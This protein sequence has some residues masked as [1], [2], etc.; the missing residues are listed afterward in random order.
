[1]QPTFLHGTPESVPWYLPAAHVNLLSHGSVHPCFWFSSCRTAS[2]FICSAPWLRF[3][4]QHLIGFLHFRFHPFQILFFILARRAVF[5]MAVNRNHNPLVCRF[6][7][8]CNIPGSRSVS[9]TFPWF[10]YLLCCLPAA[11]LRLFWTCHR[12]RTIPHI[13]PWFVSSA[14][15]FSSDLLMACASR[16]RYS[17]SSK[18]LKSSVPRW[19]SGGVSPPL[20]TVLLLSRF[21]G[22]WPMLVS[23]NADGFFFVFQAHPL[24]P[25]VFSQTDIFFL[26]IACIV[27]G[28]PCG[29]FSK[30]SQMQP[31]PS[32]EWHCGLSPG[33][34][35][36]YSIQAPYGQGSTVPRFL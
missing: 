10:A 35:H 16:I 28:F 27:P 9:C 33:S 30:C 18:H 13:L 6:C 5:T 31:L 26:L 8:S 36:I 15:P 21:P 24:Y 29:D 3:S 17:H 25:W 34:L 19:Y 23:Q 4:Q 20:L 32:C 7:V 12:F 11:F 1:M 14:P 22:R 2:L